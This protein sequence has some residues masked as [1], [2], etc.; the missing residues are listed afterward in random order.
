MGVLRAREDHTGHQ[1][2]ARAGPESALLS[3]SPFQPP[4]RELSQD[5][6]CP[7]GPGCASCRVCRGP[8]PSSDGKS[9]PG[10][11]HAAQAQVPLQQAPLLTH[12]GPRE[13]TRWPSASSHSLSGLEAWRTVVFFFSDDRELG[14]AFVQFYIFKA[15]FSNSRLGR[16]S[17][18][19]FL[20][21][22]AGFSGGLLSL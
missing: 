10:Q 8:R 14:P 1:T 3:P 15:L 5:L 13:H 17:R 4:V 12:V 20:P 21:V 7:Q 11:P 9:C 16:D 19:G 2:R 18:R 6:R 22:W